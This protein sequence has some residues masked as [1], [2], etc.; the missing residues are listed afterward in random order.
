MKDAKF[1]IV[2]TAVS[3]PPGKSTYCLG[4]TSPETSQD[5]IGAGE[6]SLYSDLGTNK[7]GKDGCI[8]GKHIIRCRGIGFVVKR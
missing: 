5:A 7:Y 3:E 2:R 6:G 4:I 1:D 8:P